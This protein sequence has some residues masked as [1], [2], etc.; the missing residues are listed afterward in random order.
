MGGA[1]SSVL[2]APGR[3]V[4]NVVDMSR[5]APFVDAATA[6]DPVNTT[7]TFISYYTYGQ[8]LALGIDL[9][10]RSRFPGKTLDD[11]MRAMWRE[12][13]DIAEAVHAGRSAADAGR[14][15][16]QGIRRRYFPAPHLRQGADGLRGAAG[17][18]RPAAGKA[19]RRGRAQLPGRAGRPVERS[20]HGDHQP[21]AERFAAVRRRSGPRRRASPIG[22]AA[23]RA[24]S[25]TWTR[26]WSATSPATRST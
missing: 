8:A 13:P 1:V 15:D 3:L 18:R 21:H 26:C 2:T 19:H 25:A 22:T 23:R 11:W 6:N 16:Q 4:F 14:S 5:H 7:N 9:S 10:I 12:H 20:R 17:A 24:R